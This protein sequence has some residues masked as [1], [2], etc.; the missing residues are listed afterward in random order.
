MR[1]GISQPE[2]FPYLGYFLKMKAVDLFI[3]L[4]HVQYGGRRSFQNRNRFLNAQGAVEYFTVPVADAYGKPINEIVTGTDPNWRKK[5][6][7]KLQFRFNI[8]LGAVYEHESLV[9]I[10]MQGIALLRQRF[11]IHTPMVM[12]SSLSSRTRKS[13]L[14]ADLCREVGATTYLCGQGG[15][16]YLDTAFF[17]GVSVEYLSVDVPDYMTALSYEYL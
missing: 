12:S 13:E 4:D 9:Q 2:H 14:L 10:N 8:D 16:A 1:V 15:R 7:R 17:E 11:G 3:V 5:I 6:V